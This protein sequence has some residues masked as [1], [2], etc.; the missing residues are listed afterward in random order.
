MDP[1]KKLACKKTAS[2]K[3]IL[4]FN[5]DNKI[6]LSRHIK[7]SNSNDLHSRA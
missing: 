6:V 5:N 1:T 4:I 7:E 3:I 2:L